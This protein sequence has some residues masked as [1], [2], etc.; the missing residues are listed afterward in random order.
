MSQV[1]LIDGLQLGPGYFGFTDPLTGTWKP[2]KFRA[3]GTTVND[4]T[5]WSSGI[6]G[7][8]LSGYP[9]INGFDGNTSTFVYANNNST[10]TW[11]APKK[12]TGQLIEVYV[13]GGNTHPIV[14]V[15]GQNTGTVVGGNALNQWVD[16]TDLCGGPGGRLETITAFGQNI[17]GVDRSSGW[18]AVRVDGVTL[19]D[20]TTTNLDFGTTGF[21]LPMDGNSPIGQDKSGKG[22][23]FTPVRFGGSVAL[24]NP[25]VSGA[26]PILNTTQGGSQ[27][28]VGVFGSKQNVGYAVTVYN[29]GGGNKYY[30]DGVKQDTVTGLIRGATYTFDTSD[31]TVSSHPFRFS[32]TSNG[33]HGGGSEYTNGV[34]AITGAATTITVPHDA[35][36]TLYYYCTSHSGMGADITGI[37]TNEKLADQYASNCTLAVPL[38]GGAK[39]VSASIACTS[40]PKAAT[41]TNANS[42][43]A[44]S[45]FYSGSFDFDGSGD[46]ISYGTSS[47][48]DFGSGD[49]TVECWLYINSHAGDKTIVGSWEGNISWQLSYGADSG[50]NKFAFMMYDGSTTFAASSTLSTNMASRWV[51]LAGIRNGNELQIWVNG[52]KEGTASFSGS[53][54]TLN[55]AI[56]IGGRSSGNQTN[57]HIQDVRIYKGVAK[58]TSNFVVPATSPDILPDTPSGVSG[59]SK[60]AKITDGAVSFEGTDFLGLADSTDTNFGSGDFLY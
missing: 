9:A 55:S 45:N 32:A 6:P 33:S 7:N 57:A 37:S 17:G 30:I 26:R 58:Y 2:K 34:A 44:Q 39:D 16:V 13:Y 36:N 25:N 20:S 35:P 51:H 53:H 56:R 11:T 8:V 27:A 47:E 24:D 10:M 1:Y 18:S 49:C 60:L 41:V 50:N 19:I 23:D 48:M 43:S 31:S 38:V 3:K 14:L 12:I 52:I 54:N 22:N 15:N 59:G 46:Y 28:G 4:G 42:S 5:V 40:T 29:D 21:Y